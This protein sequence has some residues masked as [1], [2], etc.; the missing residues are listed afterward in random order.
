MNIP[1]VMINNK[2]IKRETKL[3]VK[4]LGII[5]DENLSWDPEINKTI[6]KGYGKLKQAF[7][8]H[9]FLTKESKISIVQSYLLSQFNYNSIILQNLNNG[10]ITKIQKFQN[11]CTRFILNLRKY[12]HITEGFNSLKFLNMENSRKLQSL[13]LMHKIVNKLAP[14][15]LINKLT[16]NINFHDHL[17]RTRNNIHTRNSRTNFGRNCFFNSVGRLY[18]IMMNELNLSND[19]SLNIFK[20]RVKNHFLNSQLT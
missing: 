6:S 14:V 17:T 3:N 2:I 8:C 15:Y 9:K 10:Q 16:F 7:R 12:D 13:S 4:N 18:N 20:S 1:D 5:F 11:T 19:V